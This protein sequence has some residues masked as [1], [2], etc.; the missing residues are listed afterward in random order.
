MLRGV[1]EEARQKRVPRAARAAARLVERKAHVLA[2]GVVVVLHHDPLAARVN[3]I[4]D[5]EREV[6]GLIGVAR[7]WLRLYKT[8]DGKVRAI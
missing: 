7:E 6:P 1:D 5:V 2:G 4:D 8:A 3:D